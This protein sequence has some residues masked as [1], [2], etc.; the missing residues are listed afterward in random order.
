MNVTSLGLITLNALNEIVLGQLQ[1][2]EDPDWRKVI[3]HSLLNTRH[4]DFDNP[5][6]H[7]R[8][9]ICFPVVYE[10]NLKGLKILAV[11]G[12]NR[13]RDNHQTEHIALITSNTNEEVSE[14]LSE[15][16]PN[17]YSEA[18]GDGSVECWPRG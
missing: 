7:D 12:P 13:P 14:W 18:S 2:L 6:P 3:I 17:T 11:C 8:Y 4:L 16:L 1:C 5:I 10:W 9:D 15:H